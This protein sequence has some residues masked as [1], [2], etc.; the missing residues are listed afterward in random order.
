[1][2]PELEEALFAI[3]PAW[4]DREDGMRSSMNFGFAVGDG[5]APLVERLLMAAKE[6][7]FTREN[8]EVIQVKQKFGGLRFYVR[9]GDEAF[10]NLVREAERESYTTC[11]TCGGQPASLVRPRNWSRTLCAGCAAT[12]VAA[13]AAQKATIKP[14]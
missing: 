7:G 4:F 6:R 11:E 8:F 13:V 14:R 3:Q 10:G 12:A 5:W 1:M 2:K 9:G